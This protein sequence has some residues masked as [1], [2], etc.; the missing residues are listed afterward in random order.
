MKPGDLP[1][2]DERNNPVFW[3]VQR[4]KEA[5][6]FGEQL[7]DIMLDAL[8]RKQNDKNGE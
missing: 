3:E 1:P 2:D 6:K 7:R 4:K 8:Q 5:E